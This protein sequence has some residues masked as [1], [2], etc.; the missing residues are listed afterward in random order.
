[1]TYR[2]AARGGPAN[3]HRIFGKVTDIWF[4]RYGPG[5]THGRIQ[6]D[7]LITIIRTQSGHCNELD[8]PGTVHGTA[9]CKIN[10]EWVAAT[11]RVY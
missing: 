4:F 7:T 2:N 3:M 6:T 10:I 5:H 1:M 8:L 11:S 9:R